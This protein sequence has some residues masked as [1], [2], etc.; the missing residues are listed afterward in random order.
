MQNYS[1]LNQ[2]TTSAVGIKPVDICDSVN[3]KNYRAKLILHATEHTHLHPHDNEFECNYYHFEVSE[4]IETQ[5][6]MA[7]A[8]SLNQKPIDVF[9]QENGKIEIKNAGS[10]ANAASFFGQLEILS[11]LFENIDV[12]KS[13]FLGR[14]LHAAALSTSQQF[15]A[16]KN[17]DAPEI[18]FPF[19]RDDKIVERFASGWKSSLNNNDD[20][21]CEIN[22]ELCSSNV[23]GVLPGG[24]NEL[25]YGELYDGYRA[26]SQST[27][28]VQAGAAANSSITNSKYS[29]FCELLNDKNNRGAIN[30]LKNNKFSESEIEKI[31]QMVKS[32]SMPIEA[33]RMFTNLF[34]SGW[35]WINQ[36]E[37]GDLNSQPP[38]DGPI[39][40]FYVLVD[41]DG[42]V[43]SSTIDGIRSKSKI[44]MDWL[45][46]E[47]ERH[48]NK[49]NR[50]SVYF[51]IGS[52]RQCMKNDMHNKI[53][54][55]NGSVIDLLPALKEALEDALRQSNINHN[56]SI[57]E[58]KFLMADLEHM[59]KHKIFSAI[60]KS[61]DEMFREIRSCESGI[62]HKDS[63]FDNTKIFL[64]WTA[65]HVF[66]NHMRLTV[67]GANS[68]H[69]ECL[70]FDDR[71]DILDACREFYSKFPKLLPKDMSLHLHYYQ[72]IRNQYLS[73]H[74]LH[75]EVNSNEGLII[76]LEQLKKRSARLL[77]FFGHNSPGNENFSD[78]VIRQWNLRPRQ[79][80]ESDLLNYLNGGSLETQKVN[81]GDAAASSSIVNAV[82]DQQIAAGNSANVAGFFSQP[83]PHVQANQSQGISQKY[84]LSCPL[85]FM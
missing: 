19:I 50:C 34:V 44:L 20:D 12:N 15:I 82:T 1:D 22:A 85:D 45:V 14:R 65:M 31:I 73:E 13:V 42:C 46:A 53:S 36:I 66:S 33:Q 67:N 35:R 64:L 81:S 76:P 18:C 63:I 29:Q 70:L 27:L 6:N 2:P 41:Y 52:N 68:V 84:G 55:Q 40:I 60:G 57:N 11:K 17:P 39:K 16:G 47:I 21:I 72:S 43:G 30:F 75:S 83:T 38:A 54:N 23:R 56:V 48:S 78:T 4:I 77:E 9:I 3:A 10:W 59:D 79:Y 69:T 5:E 24:A 28:V 51:G 25:G 32:D 8:S 74:R 49:G 58:F 80:T 61:Y 37:A 26:A 71:T 62:Q 7:S